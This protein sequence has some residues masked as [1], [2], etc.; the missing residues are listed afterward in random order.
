MALRRF[1]TFIFIV[2]FSICRTQ[3]QNQSLNYRLDVT[4][5]DFFTGLEYARN[6]NCFHPYVAVEVG[7]NR[8]FFQQRLFPK[9][10]LGVTY[11]LLKNE[12]ILVGPTIHTSYSFLK[13][14]RNSE[15][16]HQWNDLMAGLRLETGKKWK[17]IFISEYGLIGETYFNQI[18]Q[19]RDY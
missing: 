7:I 17:Y 11:D 3:E 13:V 4:R 6:Y 14:N 5:F 2:V 9:F 16:F 10:T 19:K 8:T 15:H 12:K 1:F 18:S